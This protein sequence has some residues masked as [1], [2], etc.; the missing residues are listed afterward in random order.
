MVMIMVT[1]VIVIMI[2]L[3]LMLVFSNFHVNFNDNANVNFNH[4]VNVNDNVNEASKQKTQGLGA[5]VGRILD[6]FGVIFGDFLGSRRLPKSR[7]GRETVVCRFLV[8]FGGLLGPLLGAML[9]QNRPPKLSEVTFFDLLT[10]PKTIK[11][12]KTF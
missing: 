10:L 7:F 9:R 6:H 8:V 11:I 1:I 2:M 5:D 4:Y 12:S 3:I